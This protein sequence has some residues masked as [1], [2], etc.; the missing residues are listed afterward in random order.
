M[1]ESGMR[2]AFVVQLSNQAAAGPL[3][4]SVEEVDTGREARFSTEEELIEF[5]REG[6]N[7]SSKNPGKERSLRDD[8]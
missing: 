2:R 5:L 3:K 1:L 6:L 7:G 8:S 4:G